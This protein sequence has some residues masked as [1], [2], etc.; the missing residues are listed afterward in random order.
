MRSALGL[1]LRHLKSQSERRGRRDSPAGCRPHLERA[2]ARCRSSRASTQDPTEGRHLRANRHNS[3]RST[4]ERL[5]PN[6]G[7]LR[8]MRGCSTSN[9]NRSKTASN[10]PI[11]DRRA[12][13]RVDAGP[14]LLE[15]LLGKSRQPIGHY[16]AAISLR[17]SA[18]RFVGDAS[19]IS[20]IER[21]KV[22]R[23]TLTCCRA[24]IPRVQKDALLLSRG[25]WFESSRC[26]PNREAAR[27]H[28]TQNWRFELLPIA[29]SI[30]ASRSSDP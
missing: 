20:F 12:G 9:S 8:P 13:I 23:R 11:G 5:R 7:R 29:A 2:F 15:V 19:S 28:S 14:D 16:D 17:L 26:A 1:R 4:S 10:Q 27:G 25:R 21:E 18:E 3:R 6:S 30:G 22:G 24:P